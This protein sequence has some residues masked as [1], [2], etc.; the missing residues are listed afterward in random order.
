MQDKANPLA[1]ILSGAMLLKYGLGAENAAKRI[2]TA[3]TQT[4]LTLAVL[5]EVSTSGLVLKPHWPPLLV[6]G[7]NS[8][9]LSHSSFACCCVGH[10]C[11]KIH[12]T[13][14]EVCMSSY[15]AY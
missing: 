12:Y 15:S 8:E 14:S 2:E 13:D 7:T 6:L 9:P 10:V 3:V 4:T 11:I 5:P 1:T